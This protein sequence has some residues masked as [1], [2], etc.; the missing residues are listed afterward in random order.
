M[1]MN[2]TKTTSDY[3]NVLSIISFT[4]VKNV[5]TWRVYFIGFLEVVC[6][7]DSSKKAYISINFTLFRIFPIFSIHFSRLYYYA[8]IAIFHFLHVN[9]TLTVNFLFFLTLVLLF[10][11]LCYFGVLVD[12]TSRAVDR[13]WNFYVFSWWRHLDE[14]C[15][16]GN[17]GIFW[18]LIIYLDWEWW[19]EETV[20]G[21]T[22]SMGQFIGSCHSLYDLDVYRDWFLEV[23]HDG[24]LGKFFECMQFFVPECL[25]LAFWYDFCLKFNHFVVV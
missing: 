9:H 5:V 10:H 20:G 15:H 11:S 19:F 13:T 14:L 1:K 2:I 3:F 16:H 4:N 23:V 21:E 22:G 17:I 8:L 18:L 6:W 12:D 24:S 25:Y 7:M